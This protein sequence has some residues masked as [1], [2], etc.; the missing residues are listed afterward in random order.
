MIGQDTIDSIRDG[1]N[2][3]KVVGESVK[4]ERRGRS[5]VGLCPFHNEKSPSFHVNEERGFYHCFG[6]QESGDVFKFVMQTEGLS[7]IEAI[8]SLGER[9]G[10]EVRDDMTSEERNRADAARRRK[11]SIVEANAAAAHFYTQA[12]TKDP[13]GKIAV[14]EL[15]RRGLALDGEHAEALKAFKIGYAPEGWDALVNYFRRAG[16]DLSTAE[17]AG[18]VG[19]RQSGNSFYDRFR[20]RLMFAIIDLH[21]QVVGFS[22]RA[23]QPQKIGEEPDKAKYINSPETAVYKKRSTVFGLYQA[24]NAL[25]SGQPAVIVEGNFDVMSLHARG[26]KNVVAPLGTA[27]TS[28]QGKQI[29]RFG[30]EAIFLFDGDSAG[31]KATVSSKEPSREAGLTAKVARLPEGM[32]PDDFIRERGVEQLTNVL[33]SA[34]GMLDYLIASELDDNF[35]TNDAH[36][37]AEKVKKV[38]ALIAGEEDNTARAL[39]EQH[40]DQLAARLGV[41]DARTFRAL[42]QS[43]QRSPSSAARGARATETAKAPHR[44]SSRPQFEEV[45]LRVVGALLDFPSLLDSEELLD[46]SPHLAG[47]P[48]LAIACMHRIREEILNAANG[49]KASTNEKFEAK[50]HEALAFMPPSVRRFSESRLAV[51]LHKAKESALTELQENLK[52][53]QSWELTRLSHTAVDQI[54][55]ARSEGNFD[56]ELELLKQQ[57]QRAKKRRGL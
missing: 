27:F 35:A 8:R 14:A 2:I 9:L 42:R 34:K 10:I 51:P 17:E 36:A 47:E 41:S 1:A 33:S 53:L 16:V 43:V 4:L 21:G 44:A 48:A 25:R 23:L 50:L 45:S 29:R 5:L 32:D 28:E 7:F 40:A 37:R 13:G 19:R 22:G 11:L 57:E 6:C 52:K 31:K 38:A 54:E 24:R 46:A 55:R 20:H 26:M 39:A 30:S 12:L 18:L 3:A 49:D 15:K 56:E